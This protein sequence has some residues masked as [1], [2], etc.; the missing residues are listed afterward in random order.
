MNMNCMDFLNLLRSQL[1][2]LGNDYYCLHEQLW[3]LDIRNKDDHEIESSIQMLICLYRSLASKK[4][5][6]FYELD[7]QEYRIINDF[8]KIFEKTDLWK[9]LEGEERYF[10]SAGRNFISLHNRVFRNFKL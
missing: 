4:Y 1:E 6:N 3:S 9:N 10:V 8:S 5:V 7:G 2:E